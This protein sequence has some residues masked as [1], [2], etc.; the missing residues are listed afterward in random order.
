VIGLRR[1]NKSSR[2]AVIDD[3][4]KGVVPEHIFHIKLMNWLGVRDDQGE[5]GAD[6]GRF[7]HR[8]EGLI[9]TPPVMNSLIIVISVLIMH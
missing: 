1:I 4:R 3:L 8:A 7:D 2:L 6:H 9:V 5:H